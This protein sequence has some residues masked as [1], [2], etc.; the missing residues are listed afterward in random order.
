M[1]IGKIF[2]SLKKELK[3]HKFSGISLH[4]KSCRKDDIFFAVKG[5]KNNG[6]KYIP[7]AIKKGART[8]ISDIKF[9]GFKKKV[10]FLYSKN[11]RKLIPKICKKGILK[12]IFCC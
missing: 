6:N 9:Q 7:D 2:N 5:L 1:E 11:P 12:T 10:L 8:I 3:S 4:S